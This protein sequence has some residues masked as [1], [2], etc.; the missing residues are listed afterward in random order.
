MR[1]RSRRRWWNQPRFDVVELVLVVGFALVLAGSWV[2]ARRTSPVRP[3]ADA[4][5][6]AQLAERYG[7]SRYSRNVEEWI[8]RDFF[9]DRRGGV[10][11]DVGANHY[12]NESN[13]Y[14]LE[15]RLGWTGVAVEPL[16]EFEAEYK[17]HRPGTR[18]RAFFASDESNQRARLFY[19]SDNPL[20]TSATKDFTAREGGGMPSEID[21]PTITLNDLLQFEKID[22]IDFLSMDIELAEPKALTGFDLPR[23]APALV[24]IEAH[25][26]VR[27]W[28]LNYSMTAAMWRSA[29][30]WGR[31][32]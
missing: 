3:G 14:Y 20:V 29:S 30:T 22:R 9:Q 21:A 5:A 26:E 25:R 12:R 15:S 10:F 19:L 6:L 13:T 27:Q 8:I 11:L 1:T 32:R 16:T 23:F 4:W 31:T 7:P 18:F 24:C 28:L 2:I 17:Q